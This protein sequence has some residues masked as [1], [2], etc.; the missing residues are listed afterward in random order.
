MTKDIHEADL[1]YLKKTIRASRLI[2]E[3]M[4][5]DVIDCMNRA[6]GIRTI[7]DIYEEIYNRVDRKILSKV[8]RRI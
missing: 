2:V 5:F 1:E 7:D 8:R 3:Q 4:G 6:G